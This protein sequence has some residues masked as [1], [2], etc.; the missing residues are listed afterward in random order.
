MAEFDYGRLS[1][2]DFERFCCAL[3]AKL[4]GKRFQRFGEGRDNGV[5]LLYDDKDAGRWIIQCK[6]YKDWRTL[7]GSLTEEREKVQRLAPARY[8][9]VVSTSLT[10]ANK[11]WIRKEFAPYLDSTQS[12]IAREDIDDLLG[13]EEYRSVLMQVPELWMPNLQVARLALNHDVYGRSRSLMGLCEHE[14]RRWVWTECAQMALDSLERR[15]VV[16][17]SGDPGV[18][19]TTVAK[20]LL[21]RYVQDGYEPVVVDENVNDCERVYHDNSR[22]VFYFDDFL[23]STT[24]RCQNENG[25][26]RF[27]KRVENDSS[28]RLIFTAR[29]VLLNCSRQTL[30][31]LGNAWISDN[32]CAVEIGHLADSEKHRI[33]YKHMLFA[34]CGDAFIKVILRNGFYNKIVEH[35]NYNPRLIEFMFDAERLSLVSNVRQFRSYVH[36]L[37]ENPA[38]MWQSLYDNQLDELDHYIV[39]AVFLNISASENELLEYFDQFRDSYPSLKSKG[40]VSFRSV[41]RFLCKTVLKRV[42][43]RDSVRYELVNSSVEDFLN[44]R[45]AD[46]YCLIGKVLAARHNGFAVERLM[47]LGSCEWYP[48][49]LRKL[50]KCVIVGDRDC[51]GFLLMIWAWLFEYEDWD[52][53]EE[54]F[55]GV[56][57]MDF[58]DM[59]EYYYRELFRVLQ[60]LD[61]E[62]DLDDEIVRRFVNSKNFDKWYKESGEIESIELYWFIKRHQ[63]L[64][65]HIIISNIRD[66]AERCCDVVVDNQFQ[67]NRKAFTEEKLADLYFDVVRRKVYYQKLLAKALRMKLKEGNFP[68][69]IINIEKIVKG[70][71]LLQAV[72]HANRMNLMKQDDLD[73]Y[74]GAEAVEYKGILKRRKQLLWRQT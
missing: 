15:H 31:V 16:V 66:D 49:L 10:P 45:V 27:V 40:G 74:S 28:K 1:P 30:V 7:R 59:D 71:C 24:L 46:E 11:E 39:W 17:L 43:D 8:G 67:L 61:E 70:K 12:I 44:G 34:K 53:L 51:N 14:W 47:D 32:S 38:E 5:D 63:I 26:I 48:K 69:E 58:D 25:L 52:S 19:K 13:K 50:K 37:L 68:M 23:G 33:L 55:D 62:F 3:L 64:V 41:V 54:A 29:T 21:C 65:P 22:Q 2:M 42:L 57:A 60:I 36:G 72:V 73:V 18:G 35:R 20:M 6:R 56:H 4:E 9:V